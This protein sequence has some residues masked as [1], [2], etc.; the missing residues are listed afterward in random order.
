[1]RSPLEVHGVR[2][3][4]E[5]ARK[6]RAQLNA[7]RQQGLAVVE[8]EADAGAPVIVSLGK[9]VVVCACGNAPSAHPEWDEARCWDCGAVYHGLLW[10]A[11]LADIADILLARPLEDR[12]WKPGD[13]VDLLL[14]E[15]IERGRPM[16]RSDAISLVS[17]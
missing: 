16:R 15:N 7:L 6:H 14:A 17:E 12:K 8:W 2:S 1:M 11:D 13:T 4:D 5:Y 3:P 10:P 9:Y